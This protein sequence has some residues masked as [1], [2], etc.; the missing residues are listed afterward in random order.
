MS[1]NPTPR[2]VT[3]FETPAALRAWFEANHETAAE[4]WIGFHRKASGLPGIT[5][6]QALDEALCVGWIDGVRYSLDETS[7]AQRWTPRRKGS[8]W[9]AVNT[10]RAR[11]LIAEGRMRPAGLGAFENRVASAY[12]HEDGWPAPFTDDEL[13]RFE[14]D[15]VAW[16]DWERRPPSYRRVATHWV[17]SARRPETRRRRLEQLIEDSR[18]N[19][20]IKLLARP[21]R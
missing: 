15:A 12:S 11:E 3:F 19:R 8:N 17:T 10:R 1:P 21:T 7:F 20:P 13:A 9:S 18:E 4:L 6:Q 14:A 16:A 2:D 5:Y